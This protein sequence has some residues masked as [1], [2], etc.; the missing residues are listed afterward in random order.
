[1]LPVYNTWKETM[2]KLDFTH[3]N[4]LSWSLIRRLGEAQ[5]PPKRSHAPV[6]ANSVAAHL[7]QVGKDSS[8]KD[9]ERKV[10]SEWRC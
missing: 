6:R 8:N 4:Q 2:S 7:T 9:I 3:S 1:M 5:Q 10:G